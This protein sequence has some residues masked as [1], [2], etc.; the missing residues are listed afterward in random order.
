VEINASTGGRQITL[1]PIMETPTE[2]K[3]P[4]RRVESLIPAGFRQL[5]SDGTYGDLEFEVSS[6]AGL[7]SP[8][9]TLLVKRDGAT[10]A[11]EVVNLRELVPAWLD[12]VVADGPTPG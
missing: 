12:A 8:W 5:W 3:L 4:R 11:Q 6:G 10:I 7:G 1:D 9:L 2:V